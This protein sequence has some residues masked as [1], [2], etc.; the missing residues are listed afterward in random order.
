MQPILTPGL[1]SV[2]LRTQSDERLVLL[3]S[4]GHER[5]FAAIVDRYRAPLTRMLRRLFPG[6]P[7][8]DVLQLTFLSAWRAIERGAEVRDLSAWLHRIAHNAA[9]AEVR[10][11]GGE[12]AELDDDAALSKSPESVI[13]RRED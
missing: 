9:L 6:A 4:R 7:V 11:P 5:A 13:E 12:H 2:L 3:A 1:T 10:R 8:D